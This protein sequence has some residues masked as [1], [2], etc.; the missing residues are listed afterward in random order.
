MV[1]KKKKKTINQYRTCV[2]NSCLGQPFLANATTGPQNSKVELLHRS[3][4]EWLH[5]GADCISRLSVL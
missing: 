2:L 4:E 3:T 1:K 5:D